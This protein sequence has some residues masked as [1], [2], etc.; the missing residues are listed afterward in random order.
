MLALRS[1]PIRRVVLLFAALLA[2]TTFTASRTASAAGS[3]TIENRAPEESNGKWKFKMTIDYGSTPPLAY[4]PVVFT[5]TPKV[6]Y[7]LALTDQSPN[8][9]TLRKVPLEGQRTMNESMDLGFSNSSGDVYRK[10]KFD[11]A[12]RRDRGYEAGEYT[13]KIT[14]TSDGVQIGSVQNITLNG[15][16]TVVDRRAMVF[17]ADTKKVKPDAASAKDEPKPDEAA[18]DEPTKDET[19]AES[20]A[21]T[22]STEAETPVETPAPVPPKQG[23]CGC[24][25]PEQQG[26]SGAYAGIALVLGLATFG[27]RR[28]RSR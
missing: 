4:I 3:V 12:L 14:R 22:P 13:L 5:F 25:V 23:G 18:K 20:P 7:E 21:E 15:K 28:L 10:T 17:G 2:L 16:N 8:E 27:L 24:R 11:F 6:Y 1:A 19:A 9:P 26:G